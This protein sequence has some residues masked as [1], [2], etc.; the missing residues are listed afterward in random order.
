M[1]ATIVGRRV[2]FDSGCIDSVVAIAVIVVVWVTPKK[3]I[4]PGC[5]VYYGL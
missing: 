1:V 5:K 2:F 4:H 3:T